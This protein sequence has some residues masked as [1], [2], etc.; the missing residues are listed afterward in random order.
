MNNQPNLFDEFTP[1]GEQEWL[2]K[3][4]VDLKGKSIEALGRTIGEDIAISPFHHADSATAPTGPLNANRAN[5]QWEI[6]EN[7]TLNQDLSITNKAILHAL[8]NGT[9]AIQIRIDRLLSQ[10]DMKTLFQ[11]IEPGYI[12]THFHFLDNDHI[13]DTMT[14]FAEITKEKKTVKPGFRGSVSTEEQEIN[15]ALITWG[16]T[17]LPNFKMWTVINEKT[18]PVQSLLELIKAGMQGATKAAGNTITSNLVFHVTIETDYFT[19]IARLRALRILWAN[20]LKSTGHDPLLLPQI[21]V[22]IKPD[23]TTDPNQNLI[24]ATTMAMSAAIGGADRITIIPETSGDTSV[25]YTRM[26]RNLQH[27]LRM[28]SFLDRVVDP[29][30]GSYYVETLTNRFSEAVWDQL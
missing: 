4:V 26:A 27:I 29:A 14:A 13:L 7:F 2:E 21:A 15:D 5:N 8:E 16:K 23:P 6:A 24:R 25:R 1:T 22:V 17:A 9:E 30:A 20:V 28:E 3:V 12:S 10:A 19:E 18:E 11:D